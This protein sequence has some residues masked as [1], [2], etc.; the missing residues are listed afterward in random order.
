M[1]QSFNL[2]PV[3][4]IIKKGTRNWIEI[5]PEFK[6]ALLGIEDFSHI[7]V[8]YW[9]DRNDTN[10]KRQTLQVHPRSDSSKPLRGVFATHSPVRPNL[11]ATSL[12]RLLAVDG[13]CLLIDKI[14]ALPDSPVIDIKP[15]IPPF[16]DPDKVRIPDWLDLK[17]ANERQPEKDD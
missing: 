16:P 13:L 12:C 15:Y 1:Q 4:K 5:K 14:D 7:V 17:T 3:G 2:F 10:E 11:I 9:F 6:D 8:L